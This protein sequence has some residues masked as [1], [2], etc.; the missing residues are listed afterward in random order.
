LNRLRETELSAY[1]EFIKEL[2][3]KF[4]F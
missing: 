2:D 3:S 4:R 1:H